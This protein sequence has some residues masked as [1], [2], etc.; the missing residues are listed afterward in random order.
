MM[1]LS[2]WLSVIDM[3]NFARNYCLLNKVIVLLFLCL[4]KSLFTSLLFA[5]Y[6]GTKHIQEPILLIKIL[7]VE[8]IKRPFEILRVW[9]L[10]VDSIQDSAHHLMAFNRLVHWLCIVSILSVNGL[11][12]RA[13]YISGVGRRCR[14]IERHITL[15]VEIIYLGFL[16]MELFYF[17]RFE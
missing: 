5:R 12:I 9:W 11:I 3:F 13:W 7:F 15:V 6:S 10:L 8:L 16:F 14:N 4:E 17:T 1:V 2:K